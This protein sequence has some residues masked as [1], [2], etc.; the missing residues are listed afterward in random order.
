M[1]VLKKHSSNIK[2]SSGQSNL[3]AAAGSMFVSSGSKRKVLST[4]DQVS[5]AEIIRCLD[6][7]DSNCSFST[8]DRDSDKCKEMFPDSEIAKSYKQKANKVK[9]TVQFAL[10]PFFQ[11]I[12]L[13]ELSDL[14]FSFRFDET[15]TSQIKKQYDAYATYHSSHFGQ[16]ITSY[17]GTLFVGRCTTDDL[18]IHLN[19][20][21]EKLNLNKIHILS[22]GM[23]GPNVNLAFKRKLESELIK[24][25]KVLIDVG[26]C[27]FTLALMLF[28]R[29]ESCN[30]RVRNRFRSVCHRFIWLFQ[31]FC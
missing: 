19:E 24:D 20:M 27:P 10:A 26:S 15:T 7:V 11:G 21:L 9:Y 3:V 14:P 23:D 22:L 18:L 28:R 2:S 30:E 17:L 5:K 8:A 13:K 16:I 29:L 31:I 1:R 6:I 4:E 12:I 25:S